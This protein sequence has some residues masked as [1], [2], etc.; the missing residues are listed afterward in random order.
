MTVM[1]VLWIGISLSGCSDSTTEKIKAM[2]IIVKRQMDDLSTKLEHRQLKNAILLDS[3]ISQLQVSKPETREFLGILKQEIEAKGS[4]MKAFRERFDTANRQ[5]EQGANKDVLLDEYYALTQATNPAIFNDSLID[6]INVVADLSEGI[7]PRINAPP[8]NA[9]D[10][11]QI[12]GSQLIGNPKYGNWQSRS[13]GTSFWVWY[14]QY[15][16]LSSLFYRPVYYHGWYNNRSWSYYNDYGRDIYSSRAQRNSLSNVHQGSQ[17][18]LKQYGAKSGARTS[19]YAKSS[20]P[21]R[22][23]SQFTPSGATKQASSRR[24]SSYSGSHRSGSRS[25][26]SYGGK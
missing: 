7:L 1:I 16:L 5:Y 15:R 17:R 19:S 4:S 13:N 23:N 2:Q 6:Q 3:Y 8:R 20:S 26:G 24:A 10:E 11:N 12:P 9:R 22:T 18:Q 21:T 25:R 14:G